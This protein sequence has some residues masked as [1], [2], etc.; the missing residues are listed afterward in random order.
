MI[1][2]SL[3]AGRLVRG[4]VILVL[5]LGTVAMLAGLALAWRLSQGPVDLG[6]A[7]P[8][9]VAELNRPGAA[10]RITAAGASLAWPGFG[11]GAG[12]GLQL[13]LRDLGLVEG[14]RTVVSAAEVSV[15]LAPASLLR[16]R[17]LPRAVEARGLVVH[18]VR[19]AGGA[20]SLDQQEPD[21]TDPD[22]DAPDLVEVMRELSRPPP[23]PGMSPVRSA[24][25]EAQVLERLEIVDSVF[26]LRDREFGGLWRLELARLALRR[27]AAGGV[28]GSADAALGF[29]IV[30]AGLA[31]RAAL[32]PSGGTE[33]ELDLAPVGTAGLQA[34]AEAQ[35][36]EVGAVNGMEAAL[37]GSARLLLDEAL[38]PRS[39]SVR[40]STGGGRVLVAGAPIGFDG[41]AME[42]SAT[43]TV[44]GWTRPNAVE[45]SRLHA[46]VRAPGGAWPTT[47]VASGG[48][49]RD[50]ERVRGRVTASVDHVAFADIAGLWP[51]RL[52][53]HVR[54]WLVKNVT[55]GTARDAA[56]SLAFTASP[57]LADLVLTTIDGRVT[58]DDATIWWLR[59]VAPVEHAQALLTIR[60]PE[61]LDI[62]INSARQGSMALS[63]GSIHITGLD[64]KDQ[65]L[66]LN[67]DASGSVAEAVQLLRHP[68]LRLLSRKPI[69]MRNPG[70]S[71]A[72]HLTV[73]LPLNEDLDFDDIK[74]GAKARA[75]D[76]RLGGLVAGRD[77]ERGDVQLEATSDSFRAQ[78]RAAISGIPADL[79]VEMDFRGGGPGQVVQR[80]QALARTGPRQLVAAGLD[81]AGI[82]E[83]GQG[84]FTA[85]YLQ[86]RD[87]S[88]E[89]AVAANLRDA[90]LGLAGWS[91]RA[92]VPAE[93][94]A[95]LLLRGDRLLGIEQVRAQ[96]ADLAVEGR[97]EMV[98]GRPLLLVLDRL[99]LGRTQGSGEVMLPARAGEALRV[100][101][102]GAVLDLSALLDR[103]GG[104]GAE[105]AWIADARFDRVILSGDRSLPAVTAHAESSGGRVGALRAV[106]Q[107]AERVD[108]TIRREG[109]V[110]RLRVTAADGGAVLRAMDLVDTVQGG[111][112]ALD[113]AYDDRGAEPVL[114]GTLELNAFRVR[115]APA[116][117]K[118]LQAATVYG[119]LEALSGPGLSFSALSMPFSWDGRT[120]EMTDVQAFSASLGLTARGRVD[121]VRKTV[122]VQG[123]VVPLYML[124]SALGRIPL[125]GKL[126]TAEKGGGL[127]A[128]NY[129]VRGRL[130]NPAVSV[131]PLSA[132]TPGFL[133]GL[134]KGF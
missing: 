67:A 132:L 1:R 12:A 125:L 18:L 65:F 58:G 113:A 127:L 116:L 60:S 134:F 88:A 105:G 24:L 75:T 21:P 84:V 90:V 133:R 82:I 114:R 36:A 29:G 56:V 110:R 43:W 57:S 112:M 42:G 10:S 49:A 73:F 62:A 53:G 99:R 104:G 51:E 54:P 123:T 89:L 68:R 46:V 115:D 100:R 86:R 2:L 128:V 96:G 41:L 77:L 11:A 83:G 52:G 64:V 7:V 111:A 61:V 19:T 87:G 45:V 38:Q 74:I 130:D 92:G 97:V 109:G 80:A 6:W 71:L 85:S 39:G 119:V 70:G 44:P 94:G 33:L 122:D 121:A 48:L 63:G 47:L 129:G 76:L 118:L 55:A 95:Q 79:S 81:T 106:S 23:A 131:N 4:T 66:T 59:P 91:K 22:A 30:R 108:A 3:F 40:L 101:L 107:G 5:A 26:T 16:A 98:D 27:P 14:E 32:A 35:G 20:V 126:F 78:G 31:L 28:T 17:A 15:Q 8:R 124:N 50:G 102:Q 120:L 13:V 9:I 117:G 103:K 25:Q 93:A 37:Q 72:G 69:P 34:A